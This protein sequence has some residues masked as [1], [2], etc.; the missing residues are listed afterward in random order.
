M[1]ERPQAC[2][3]QASPANHAFPQDPGIGRLRRGNPQI[4]G[5]PTVLR[6]RVT[7]NATCWMLTAGRLQHHIAASL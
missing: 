5:A 6:T 7:R 1:L 4:S 2:R 3:W